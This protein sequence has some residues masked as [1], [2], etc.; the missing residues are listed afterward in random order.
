MW[1]ISR[2]IGTRRWIQSFLHTVRMFI[3]RP[4][5]RHFI[6]FTEDKLDFQLNWLYRLVPRKIY[7]KRSCYSKDA[8][9]FFV[10]K[11]DLKWRGSKNIR[12]AQKDKHWRRHQGID[13]ID[14][15]IGHRVQVQSGRKT[16]K[17]CSLSSNGLAPML[18]KTFLSKGNLQNEMTET[19]NVTKNRIPHSKLPW[20]IKGN[21]GISKT[22]MS[23]KHWQWEKEWLH[24]FQV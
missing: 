10:L 11:S 9:H 24:F 3:R 20:V 14:I 23:P 12:K 6:Q 22:K 8:K 19:C 16:K 7:Q 18:S 1:M 4:K 17:R 13:S 21:N 15:K 5:R 2:R